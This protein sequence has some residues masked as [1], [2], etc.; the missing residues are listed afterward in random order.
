MVD[1]QRALA[2]PPQPPPPPARPSPPT[3][4]AG[5]TAPDDGTA[6]F[7]RRIGYAIAAIPLAFALLLEL[8][9]H[10][11]LAPLGDPAISLLGLP[12]GAYLGATVLVLAI[13]GALAVRYVR[14]PVIVGMVLILT[15]SI[16]LMLVIMGP[17]VVL[18]MI[19]LNT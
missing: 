1:Q 2:A 12:L 8:L 4:W 9:S 16:G 6:D 11:F 18:I 3:G 10:D 5:S 14:S 15:T 17:A 7:S 19:N 13:L